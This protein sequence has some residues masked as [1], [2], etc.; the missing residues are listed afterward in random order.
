MTTPVGSIRLDLT[1][2]GAGALAKL[3]AAAKSAL[4]GIGNSANSTER[5]LSK[6][7]REFSTIGRTAERQAGPVAA[8]AKAVDSLGDNYRQAATSAEA[9]KTAMPSTRS[10]NAQARAVDKLAAS[11]AKLTAAQTAAAAA[12]TPSGPPPGR[13]GSGGVSRGGGGGGG[14]GGL[15]G[16]LTGPVGLNGIA[17]GASA[18]PAATLAVTNLVGAVQQLGQAGLA[19]PG[20]MAGI[21]SSA[22]VAA[23]GFK[24]M[25][26]AIKALNDGDLD[27]A[28][29][30]MKDMDPAAQN[31][32]KSVSKFTQGPLKDLTK[33][34]QAKM[35]DGVAGGFDDLVSKRMPNVTKGFGAIGE[36]WNGTLK[37]LLSTAGSDSTGGILDRIF[38]NTAEGQKRANAAIDPLVKGFGT[39]AAAGTDILPRLGD[40]LTKVATRF[41][42]FITKADQDGRLAKWIDDGITGVG[43]LGETFLNIGKSITAITKAAGGDGGLLKALETG[44]TKLATFLN[45]AQ[46]QEKLGA[47]FKDAR[48]R[49]N[50]WIPILGNVAKVVG[51]VFKGFQQ[52]GDAI[53]PAVGGITKFLAD[54]P[55]LVSTAVTA[56]AA[57][58]TL[59]GLES[60]LSKLTGVNAL[61]GGGGGVGKGGKGARGGVGGL[62]LAGLGLFTGGVFDAA[63][64]GGGWGN[65]LSTI[66]GGAL[67][68]AQIG[69]PLGAA[70]GATAA[71]PVI[72]VQDLTDRNKAFHDRTEEIKQQV[73]DTASGSIGDSIM[74]ADSPARKEL[75]KNLYGGDPTQSSTYQKIT[76][77]PGSFL[78]QATRDTLKQQIVSGEL[79]IPGIDAS[80]VDTELDKLLN[81]VN[82][83][84][85]N[86]V[87][88]KVD[89][90]TDDANTK[91][92]AFID[93]YKNSLITVNVAAAPKSAG[94][95]I[96]PGGGGGVPTWFSSGKAG[97]GVVRRLGRRIFG[98]GYD[99]GGVFPGGPGFGGLLPGVPRNI[100]DPVQ[101]RSLLEWMIRNGMIRKN[102][103]PDFDA[104]HPIGGGN[105]NPAWLIDTSTTSFARAAGGVLPGYSP[106]VDN[107]LVPLSGGEGI[108]IPEA[109]R[110]LGPQWL[111]NLNSRFRRG[112]SRSGYADGGVVDGALAGANTVVGLLMQIRD[113]LV[114]KLSGPLSDTAS[115][116]DALSGAVGGTTG[117]ATGGRPFGGDIGK[118]FISGIINGFGGDSRSLFPEFDQ[119]GNPLLPGIGGVGGGGNR[120]GLAAA[121]AKFATSGNTSDLGA[122]G[123]GAGDPVVSAIVSARNKKKNGLSDTEI[124]DLVTQVVGGGGF[125]GV[126]D[127]RNSSLVKALSTYSRKVTKTGGGLPATAAGD[128]LGLTPAGNGSASAL[129][130]FAQAA[131]GGKYAAA[132]DL[133]NGLADCSGAVSDL[134]ELVTK[135]TTSPERLFSTANEASV[136]QSLGAVPGLIPG[137]LQ[138]GLNSG[139]TAATLPNGVNF[140]SGG[141]GGGV[142]YGGDAAG[143]ADPQFTQQFSLPVN[144]TAGLTDALGT[145]G[146]NMCGCI[147]DSMGGGLGQLGKD[148]LGGIGGVAGDVGGDIAKGLFGG[149][150]TYKPSGP[151]AD[152]VKLFKEGNPA[153]LATLLGLNVPDMSRNGA[154]S[155]ADNLMVNPGPGF[156]AQGRMFSDTALLIDRSMT[157]L[158]T[159]M[160]AK[161]QQMQDVLNQIRDQ[162]ADIASKLVSAAAS[163]GTSV[164]QAAIPGAATGG[165]LP[166]YSPGVDNLVATL[167]GKPLGLSGG[168][169]ILIPEAV[170]AIGGARGVY[171]L[172]SRY[173]SGLPRTNYRTGGMRG[174]ADG[175]VVND[176]V[177]ADF[178]GLSEVPIIGGI[179]NMLVSILLKILG[180]E[181]QSRDTLQNMSKA[182][183]EF[184]GDFQKFDASGRLAS[185][186]SGLID[187]NQSDKDV[188]NKE[189]VRILT[190]VIIGVI[191]YVIEKIIM[192][193]INSAIQAAINFGT[194]AISSAVGMGVNAVA[195]GAGG[196][197]GGITNAAV[198]ALGSIAQTG[199]QI[200]T[201]ILGSVLSNGAEVLIGTLAS[202][203]P[204]AIFQIFDLPKLV[205]TI[206]GGVGG[207]LSGLVGG[208]GGLVGGFFDEG[209]IASGVGFMPKNTIQPERVLSPR[210]TAAFENAM[211]SVGGMSG[212][213]E[214]HVT[215]HVTQY[216]SGYDPTAVGAATRD[217]LDALV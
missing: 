182:V 201:E 58:G 118:A 124:A 69:G 189:R 3:E 140:E 181:I 19:L 37:Q 207:L 113:A 144:G 106:G 205:G 193:L 156:D 48:D 146:Q 67:V 188:V 71:I 34:L 23:L 20:I 74:P 83:K 121:L 111:F 59:K 30:A 143:A 85:A 180:I 169:G 64:N 187:R 186:S 1:I 50:E 161:F 78:D 152:P 88:L 5:D 153:A 166:G 212:G 70:V 135:G 107:M 102:L 163:A 109:M 154:G 36:A 60:L 75:L 168:E 22:G 21:A 35:F 63:T 123:L 217:R 72:L 98:R 199:G 81:D 33:G 177:G 141:S 117:V 96:L 204:S 157:S 87:D 90:K 192:P 115:G 15:G 61:L 176:T 178:F 142:R 89:A 32:A 10:L 14:R 127:D 215:N 57:F 162:L 39:L 56:F 203:I 28:A 160:E 16:F 216:F 38:G 164:G 18:L 210:Q 183:R 114:G 12:P 167:N 91:I 206:F 2:D 43:H 191:K 112:L 208:L 150:N 158:Q 46:G 209:G 13:G 42:D 195:P 77:G 104:N 86:P 120:S 49:L 97:G 24:G 119:K 94:D 213:P 198:S 126:L 148:L 129:I 202:S 134:V 137:T 54:M 95:L 132:S 211:R 8:L 175:G 136:L 53:L 11:Y 26:D 41:S 29:K 139:H 165:V 125:S 25:G 27:K 184:R 128:P 4:G 84:L 194:Q 149:G 82:G 9:F 133:A 108:I 73:R 62:G 44:S 51:E 52:W 80:N 76:G 171:A 174:F 190:Q 99:N 214:K 170:R 145:M 197:A 7:E 151:N 6:L 66:A 147:G 110:A 200:F 92:K 173:R 17:L 40:G 185:D 105:I 138:I 47:F 130:A 100:T 172:N 55:G 196:A 79:K 101:V 179:V 31:L 45:S 68:G 159:V 65:A 122:T 116:V 103:F 131:N 93:S 155:Q